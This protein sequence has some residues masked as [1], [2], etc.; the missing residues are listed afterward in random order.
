MKGFH[1]TD[2]FIVDVEETVGRINRY[3]SSKFS[4][5]RLLRYTASEL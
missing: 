2:E 5:V 4:P 3:H 1:K